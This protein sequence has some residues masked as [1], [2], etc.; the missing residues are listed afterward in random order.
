M[1]PDIGHNCEGVVRFITHI[2]P[3]GLYVMCESDQ[4][5]LNTVCSMRSTVS[6][7]DM[8]R[9]SNCDHRCCLGKRS[10]E[11]HRAPSGGGCVSPARLIRLRL[12][13]RQTNTHTDVLIKSAHWQKRY[14]FL[15]IIS[16]GTHKN[17][18]VN[19]VHKH[20]L[21]SVLMSASLSPSCDWRSVCCLRSSSI[22][23]LSCV[24]SSVCRPFICE[25]S[26]WLW[27]SLPE[28]MK[29]H[30]VKMSDST[31]SVKWMLMF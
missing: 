22:S 1:L 26:P 16:P 30:S 17:K 12:K 21:T 25:P 23:S 20:L 4:R 8:F 28:V 11:C 13:L 15:T 14:I 2:L 5:K 3:G 7:D 19:A 31:E 9:W 6:S 27:L 24:S 10:P 18:R 29:T